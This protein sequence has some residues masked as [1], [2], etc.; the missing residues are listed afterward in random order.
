MGSCSWAE[1][2]QEL[3]VFSEEVGALGRS[4]GALM[5]LKREFSTRAAVREAIRENPWF[6][7]STVDALQSSVFIT[8]GRIFDNKAPHSVAR[9]LSM[10]ASAPDMFGPASL[11]ER[12]RVKFAEASAEDQALFGAVAEES[13]YQPSPA[14]FKRLRQ[15][16]KPHRRLFE[17]KHEE[18]RN[19]WFAH[20]E[21]TKESASDLFAK[22]DLEE[23]QKIAAFLSSLDTELWNAYYNGS[24][25]EIDVL[26]AQSSAQIVVE[27]DTREML[28]RLAP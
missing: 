21:H 11:R 8:L 3:S 28:K 17:S 12:R 15:Q 19:K 22:A 20:R 26:R 16:L 6:W 27:K 14:D 24:K 4:V 1:F 2:E 7:S 10:A 5:T 25:P 9:L 23:I 18:I 13:C